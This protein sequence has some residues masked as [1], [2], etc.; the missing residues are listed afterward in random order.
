MGVLSGHDL[1]VPNGSLLDEQA[2]P[3]PR[4]ITT[5]PRFSPLFNAAEFTKVSKPYSD[6]RP[7]KIAYAMAYKATL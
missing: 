6:A 7:G 1:G 2:P 4:E 5:Q 3:I